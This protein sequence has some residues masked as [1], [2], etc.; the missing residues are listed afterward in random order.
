MSDTNEEQRLPDCVLITG[1]NRNI[2]AHLAHRFLDDGFA[3]VAQYRND[4]ADMRRLAERGAQLIQ[5]NFTT[6]AATK[7]IA[8]RIGDVAPELRAIVHNA[9]AFGPTR[10]TLDS[11]AEQFQI[12]FDVHMLAPYILN[13]CLASRIRGSGAMPGDIIHITD[14]YADNPAPDYDIYCATKAALQN[15]SL[16]FAKRLAP[17]V[18][19]NAIQPGPI[20]FQPWQDEYSAARVLA[21]TPLAR[22]GSAEDIYTAVRAIMANGYQTGAVI[23][24]DGG[25]RLGR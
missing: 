15:L 14:I 8:Y 10:Q 3:V 16:A 21:S 5:G 18:K 11:A 13:T 2:G 22:P 23:P 12:F 1:S 24:V 25:R 9:S 17:N 6:A 4:S 7:A 19:V 20:S